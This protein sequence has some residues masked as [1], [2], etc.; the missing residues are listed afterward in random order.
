MENKKAENR[1]SQVTGI[2][3]F[4]YVRPCYIVQEQ[5]IKEHKLTEVGISILKSRRTDKSSHVLKKAD[6]Q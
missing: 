4:V 1:V 3:Q 6:I 5:Q 2:K